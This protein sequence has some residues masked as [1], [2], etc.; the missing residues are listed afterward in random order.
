MERLSWF[1][2]QT[3]H[4]Q[5]ISGYNQ[6]L[7]VPGNSSASHSQYPRKSVSPLGHSPLVPPVS[8]PHGVHPALQPGTHMCADSIEGIYP[9]FQVPVGFGQ[10]DALE[11]L[12]SRKR[13]R[14]GLIF[15]SPSLQGPGTLAA[16]RPDHSPWPQLELGS[17]AC[18]L[19][20][21]LRTCRL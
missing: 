12:V 2:N 9:A 14:S 20:L 16:A 11:E 1:L 3:Q 15:S 13:G 18:S 4:Q 21:L 8:L 7:G 17:G 5:D 10:M 19:T 6:S